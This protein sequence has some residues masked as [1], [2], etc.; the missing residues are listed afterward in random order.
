[1]TT[2]RQIVP[3]S[4]DG[5]RSLG[6]RYWLE[7]AAWSRG[8]IRHRE[9][10][11]GPEL[12]LLGADPALVRLGHAEVV[13]DSDHVRCRYPIRGGLLTLGAGGTLELSQRGRGPTRLR[14]AVEGFL[15]RGGVVF[16]LQRRAHVA[17]SRRFFRRLVAEDVL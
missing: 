10:A 6:R 15:A 1:M 9:T 17:I 16:A 3:F 2:V 11:D 7:V 5:A 12:S 8:L 14:V 4:E 13:V